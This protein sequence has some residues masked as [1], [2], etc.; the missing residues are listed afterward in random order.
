ME[1]NKRM[2]YDDLLLLEFTCTELLFP[3]L[4]QTCDDFLPVEGRYSIF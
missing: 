3:D 4:V 1:E 2:V